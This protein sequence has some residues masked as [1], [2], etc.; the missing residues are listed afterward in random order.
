[1]AVVHS[2]EGVC[3]QAAVGAERLVRVG[4]RVGV[5]VR[6]RVRVRVRVRV[7]A[8]VRARVRIT[9]RARVRVRVSR[10]PAIPRAERRAA[11]SWRAPDQG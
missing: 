9:V 10:A 6:F 11:C 5:G 1:M 2:E 4:V 7:R 3:R 8:R